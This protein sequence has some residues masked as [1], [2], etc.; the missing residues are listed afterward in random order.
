M[1]VFFRWLNPKPAVPECYDCGS[2]LPG[3]APP[4]LRVTHITQDEEKLILRPQAVCTN[5]W[6]IYQ[7]QSD[8]T[9]G[10]M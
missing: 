4:Y 6:L 7:G 10:I 5:C 8:Q 9:P 3:T 2:L 1:R